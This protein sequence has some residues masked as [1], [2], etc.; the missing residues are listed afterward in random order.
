VTEFGWT[1]HPTG[2]LDWAPQQRRP[3]YISRTTAALGHVD[4]GLAMVILYTWVTPERDLADAQDWFGINPPG[5]GGSADTAAFAA[6]L[7]D[8]EAPGPRVSLCSSG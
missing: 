3:G 1:T 2:A 7:R 4:C 6:G 8:G 5:G